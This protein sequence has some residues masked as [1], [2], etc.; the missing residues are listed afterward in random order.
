M[1][2]PPP[3]TRRE[4]VETKVGTIAKSYG[5]N[6]VS[7]YGS[8]ISPKTQQYLESARN[9]I[10]SPEQQQAMTP[11][12]VQSHFSIYLTRFLRSSF[13]QPFR[14]TFARRVRTIAFGQP[15]SELPVIINAVHSLTHLA[16]AS[17]QEDSY[18]KVSKDIPL[19]LNTFIATHQ[20]LEQFVNTLPQHWTD[21]EFT[22]DQRQTEDV[23]ALLGSL[24]YGLQELLK[25]FGV[26]ATQLSLDDKDVRIARNIAGIS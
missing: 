5:N 19:L 16:T 26:Y 21:V 17:L 11:A 1:S 10:F 25:A 18:G 3:K 14:Q 9:S 20:V 15:Y 22:E 4:R 13:G 6:P 12:N 7:G 2:T 8:P 23:R 24:K